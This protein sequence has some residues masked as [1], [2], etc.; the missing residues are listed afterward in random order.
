MARNG[1]KSNGQ[2]AAGNP[3]GLGRPSRAIEAEYLGVLSEWVTIEKW[4]R[5][6]A[7]AADDAEAGDHRARQWL[8][9]S[10][11]A[12]HKMTNVDVIPGKGISLLKV[13]DGHGNRELLNR[14]IEKRNG[15]QAN[16]RSNKPT[17]L[18]QYHL[19]LPPIERCDHLVEPSAARQR[20]RQ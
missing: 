16:A 18:A 10:L 14:G 3:G 1:R 4:R 5:I 9:Q 15:L 17:E 2:F 13:D 20:T 7:R 12:D 8:G 6:V 11:I 19:P